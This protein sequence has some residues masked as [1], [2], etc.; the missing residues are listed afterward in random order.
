[1]NE[2]NSNYPYDE[3]VE[4]YSNSMFSSTRNIPEQ[5]QEWTI[6][7]IRLRGE[8]ISEWALERWPHNRV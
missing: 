7:S 4:S 6:D 1:M 8:T 2:D 3:K 5:Y